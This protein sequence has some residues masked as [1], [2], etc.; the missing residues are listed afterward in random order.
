VTELLTAFEVDIAKFWKVN[1]KFFDILT[2]SELEAVCEE[3]GIAKAMGQ[4]EFD[5]A[6]GGKKDEFIK[7][8]LNVK[9]F[10]Y[11]GKIPI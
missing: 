5:K 7:L 8:A 2:K 6:K 1:E 10:E 9:D 4:K 3:I 11:Q